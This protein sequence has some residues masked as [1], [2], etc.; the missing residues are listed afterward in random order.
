MRSVL[1]DELIEFLN[2]SHNEYFAACEIKNI[3][4]KNG[5]K[6]LREN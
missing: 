2:K 1:N 5:F 4:L 6:E 3:L